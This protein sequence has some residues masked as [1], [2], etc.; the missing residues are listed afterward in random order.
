MRLNRLHCKTERAGDP[1]TRD[2]AA[3][4]AD[5]RAAGALR[6]RRRRRPEPATP[7]DWRRVRTF[8]RIAIAGRKPARRHR[9]A[10]SQHPR[11]PVSRNEDA[12]EA[13]RVR[14]RCGHFPYPLN[15]GAMSDIEIECFQR[16]IGGAEVHRTGFQPLAHPFANQPSISISSRVALRPLS[17]LTTQSRVA[18]V[19]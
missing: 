3:I 17:P 5:H 11:S 15:I 8:E 4:F 7:V 19:G 13:Y 10:P 2:A 12:I 6:R 1:M 14:T 9:R 18:I 16:G